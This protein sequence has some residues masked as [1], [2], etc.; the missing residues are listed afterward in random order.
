MPEGR[1][2]NVTAL[3]LAWRRDD[4]HALDELVPIVYSEL[5]RLAHARMRRESP[6]Q[7]TLQT[8]ALVHE[9]Y[10]R[11]VDGTRVSWQNRVH[12]YAVCAQVMRRILVDRARARRSL[13]RDGG[14]RIEIADWDGEVPARNEQLLA[15][16]EALGRLSEADPHRGRVVELRYFGG[17]TLE[18]TAEALEV[19]VDR[20]RRD[21][22]VARMWL[23]RQ[24]ETEVTG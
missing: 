1:P 24:L 21:W 9:V 18:E 23:L 10:L 11:L 16:D 12:F 15:L 13:K 2:A 4:A 8:T 19:S 20:V 3:L 14:V 6:G 5:R 22:R 7:V 17:L